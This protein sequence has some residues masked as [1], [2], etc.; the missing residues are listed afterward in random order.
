MLCYAIVV[1]YNGR[2]WLDKCIYSLV[3]SS[4]SNNII[5][6]DN[7]SS[8]GTPETIRQNFP[9][10]EIIETH[11]NLGFG[12]A[13]NIGLKKAY[14]AGADYVFL[15][16]Q[17]AWVEPDGIEKLVEAA[18]LQPEYGIVSPIHL[19]GSGEKLDKNFLSYILPQ[20]CLDLFSDM[21][22]RK[23]KNKIYRMTFVNAAGWL[24][25]RKTIAM[26][27]GFN[28]LFFVYCEDDNY[29]HRLRFHGLDV[30]IFPHTNIYHDRED[31]PLSPYFTDQFELELRRV[32]LKYTNPGEKSTIYGFIKHLYRE[33]FLNILTFRVSRIQYLYK[34]VKMLNR[35]APE[36]EKTKKISEKTGLSFL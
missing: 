21:V 17:D 9:E 2:K 32:M 1:T 28:P 13:N 27:G 29:I 19:N 18:R 35:L 5:V 25:S 24:I 11:Q 31:R 15:L 20:N 33:L 23:L 12:K 16:N 14:D 34:L 30:G 7:G 4:V 22:A 10:V 3:N 36:I 26:G 6:V 8:D